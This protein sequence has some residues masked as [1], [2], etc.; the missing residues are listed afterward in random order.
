MLLRKGQGQPDP[1]P[2]LLKRLDALARSAFPIASAAVALLLLAA[3][4]NLPPFGPSLMLCCTFF[5]SLFRPAGVPAPAVFLLGLLQDLL[6]FS[7]LGQGVLIL[8]LAHGTALRLRHILVKQSFLLVWLAF[9][10]IALSLCLLTY[11]LEML[12]N[13]HVVPISFALIEAGLACGLYPLVAALLTRV[14]EAI[15]HA[16]ALA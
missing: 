10:L 2:G 13:W 6:S 9:C 16:E 1:A 12:L 15:Q 4:T 14:H 3:P 7:P 5:W 8:L 11:I